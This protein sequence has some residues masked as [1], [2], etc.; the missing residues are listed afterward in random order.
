MEAPGSGLRPNLRPGDGVMF[1]SHLVGVRSGTEAFEKSGGGWY[2]FVSYRLSNTGSFDPLKEVGNLVLHHSSLLVNYQY[3]HDHVSKDVG[4]NR[5]QIGVRPYEGV[6]GLV[7]SGITMN[8]T[9][10]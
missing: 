5:D 7:K 1:S 9:V 2:G 10:T 8:E 6:Y 3:P 4:I